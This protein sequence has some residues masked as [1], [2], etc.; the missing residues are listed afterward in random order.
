M[1]Y[2]PFKGVNSSGCS[3][4]FSSYHE[5]G[6]LTKYFNISPTQCLFSGFCVLSISCPL[7]SLKMAAQEIVFNKIK[8]KHF[9]RSQF[10][11]N[12]ANTSIQHKI[13]QYQWKCLIVLVG[14]R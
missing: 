6:S 4:L 1:K 5:Q 10:S 14:I 9:F 13:I 7:Y 8:D 3:S 12:L 2:T 11:F